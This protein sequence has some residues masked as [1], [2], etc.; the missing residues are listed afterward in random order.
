[1]S[2]PVRI[3]SQRLRAWRPAAGAFASGGVAVLALA[4]AVWIGPQARTVHTTTGFV[5]GPPIIVTPG[6]TASLENQAIWTFKRE[7]ASTQGDG[8]A[9][10]TGAV[11]A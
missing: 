6:R 9:H 2:R 11:L 1:M 10:R 8:S 5:G 4:L 3:S 7:L